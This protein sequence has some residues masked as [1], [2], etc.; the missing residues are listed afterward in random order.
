VIRLT[1]EDV[2][3]RAEIS[4]LRTEVNRLSERLN[5]M[6]DQNVAQNATLNDAV[7]RQVRSEAAH[8]ETAERIGAIENKL[9]ALQQGYAALR[10]S[11]EAL[12]ADLMERKRQ[13]LQIEADLRRVEQQAEVDISE[14]RSTNQSLAKLVLEAR[15]MCAETSISRGNASR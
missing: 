3:L 14:M 10:E 1:K 8:A 7:E 15:R 4:S 13:T 2:T 11:T 6:G 5:A 12:D 9:H